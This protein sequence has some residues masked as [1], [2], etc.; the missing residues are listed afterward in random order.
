MAKKTTSNNDVKNEEIIEKLENEFKFVNGNV[1]RLQAAFK[2]GDKFLKKV[3]YEQADLLV[4]Q[5]EAMV[6][7]RNVLAVRIQLLKN[8]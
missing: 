1:Q 5:L 8:I 7:Y 3:G 2:Q 6:T 4:D